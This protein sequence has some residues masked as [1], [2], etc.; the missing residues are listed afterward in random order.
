MKK[1]SKRQTP[2]G[3]ARREFL[4]NSAIAGAGATI[5]TA[6][7]GAAAADDP[8]P[9]KGQPDENYRLTRHISDYY[10]TLA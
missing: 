10:K 3:Q 4:R 2:S 1:Q 9:E 5:A 8:G 6:L 7:P